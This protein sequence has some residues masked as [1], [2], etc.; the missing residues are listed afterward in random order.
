MV[1]IEKK[2]HGPQ[3]EWKAAEREQEK[4]TKGIHT[5]TRKPEEADIT[6]HARAIKRE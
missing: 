2:R 1:P 3:E 4:K 5:G 6:E